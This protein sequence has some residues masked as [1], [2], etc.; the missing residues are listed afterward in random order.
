MNAPLRLNA[1]NIRADGER[2]ELPPGTYEVPPVAPVDQYYRQ[3]ELGRNSGFPQLLTRCPDNGHTVA[4][5]GTGVTLEDTFDELREGIEKGQIHAVCAV[6]GAYDWLLTRG[7]VPNFAVSSEPRQDRVGVFRQLRDDVQ[8]L[9][10]S[11]CHPDTWERF[12][13]RDVVV[14]HCELKPSWDSLHP[15]WE[16]VPHVKGGSSSGLRAISL[17]WLYGFYSQRLFGFDCTV[18]HDGRWKVTGERLPPEES[19]PIPVSAGTDGPGEKEYLTTLGLSAQ[20]QSLRMQLRH[21]PG[22]RIT[23][24]G[25][26]LLQ[27]TLKNGKASGWPV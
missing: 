21:C 14:W 8:Y 10:A 17:M 15:G 11:H 20:V 7:I 2:Q 9:F 4:I 25:D 5:V 13:G 18:A 26:G 16:N 23:A 1:I 6:K 24:A 3:K 19:P 27:E 22:I 12:R